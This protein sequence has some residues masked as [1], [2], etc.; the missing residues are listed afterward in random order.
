MKQRWQRIGILAGT[1]FVINV[2]GRLVI[3]L[4]SI[5]EVD[6][7]LTLT[8]LAYGLIALVMAVLAGWWGQQHPLGSVIGELSAAVVAAGVLILGVGPFISGTTPAAVGAGDT[9]NAAWQY[10]GF[11]AGGTALGLMVITMLG[12]DY[13][14][15]SLQRFEEIKRAKPKRPVRR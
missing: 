15:R 3:R 5:D 14:S 7:Q 12:K 9:F 8:L 2:I 11:A 10:A 13:T 4:G 6:T 1:L